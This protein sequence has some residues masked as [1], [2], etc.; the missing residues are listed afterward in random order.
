L[1]Y[2]SIVA[3]RE[4][5]ANRHHAAM[6]DM[7]RVISVALLPDIG[8]NAEIVLGHL[9]PIREQDGYMAE[10]WMG[11]VPAEHALVVRS[12]LNSGA[13]FDRVMR[14][15]PTASHYRIHGDFYRVLAR[16]RGRL[17]GSAGRSPQISSSVEGGSLASKPEKLETRIDP[18]HQLTHETGS[19]P[20]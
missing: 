17:L 9:H 4:F 13:T 14:V 12:A 1:E 7:E 5:E 2:L 3:K 15:D 11:Q 8:A 18:H 20:Q 19:L 16:I 10:V 6:A